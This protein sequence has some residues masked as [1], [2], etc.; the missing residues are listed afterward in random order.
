MAM[1]KAYSCNDKKKRKLKSGEKKVETKNTAEK[2]RGNKL[3]EYKRSKR[4]LTSYFLIYMG[5][6]CIVEK[7]NK[8]SIKQK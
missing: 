4:K 3:I 2:K 6:T 8:R 7:N 5:I 1:I